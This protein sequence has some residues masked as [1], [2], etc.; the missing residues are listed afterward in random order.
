[1]VAASL[2]GT[3]AAIEYLAYEDNLDLPDSDQLLA[4]PAVFARL[5]RS[6]QK[7]AALGAVVAR[8]AA[9]PKRRQWRKAFN[10]CIQA[11]RQGAPDIAAAAAM[12][13][14]DIKPTAAGLP[15]GHEAFTAILAQTDP[16]LAA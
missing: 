15:P 3:G 10:V 6:D 7:H 2:V 5:E 12:R 1:M 16:D 14:I 11:A 13:L 8:V 9:D 4:D